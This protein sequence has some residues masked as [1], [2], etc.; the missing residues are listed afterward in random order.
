MTMRIE[1]TRE[2]IHLSNEYPFSEGGSHALCYAFEQAGM[3]SMESSS[4]SMCFASEARS[5]PSFSVDLKSSDWHGH[6]VLEPEAKLDRLLIY[7]L[8]PGLQDW[9][10]RHMSYGEEVG[11]FSF[12]L[13]IEKH[14]VPLG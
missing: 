11:P 5:N 6:S 7:E 4:T 9:M 13:D 2:Q 1:I 3:A 8:I 12:E 10:R 14:S